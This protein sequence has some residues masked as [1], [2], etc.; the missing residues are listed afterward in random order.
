MT[1]FHLVSFPT[2]IPIL[3]F[4]EQILMADFIIIRSQTIPKDT[5]I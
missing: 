5:E 4:Q 1:I 3:L 2:N